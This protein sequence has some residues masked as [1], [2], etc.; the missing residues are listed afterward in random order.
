MS[1]EVHAGLT[2]HVDVAQDKRK[3]FFLELLPRLPCFSRQAD[4]IPV[5]FQQVAQEPSDGLLVVDDEDV[6]VF[7]ESLLGGPLGDCLD[8]HTLL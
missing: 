8:T 5:G 4:H 3:T 6:P 1:D 7:K 2:G